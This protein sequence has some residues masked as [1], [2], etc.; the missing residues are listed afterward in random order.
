MQDLSGAHFYDTWVARD[1]DGSSFQP[2]F[3]FVTDAYSLERMALGLPFPVKCCWN[4]MVAMNA[5]PIV[6]HG[7][8]FRR[9]PG[10]AQPKSHS[11]QATTV[12]VHPHPDEC[13]APCTC[14]CL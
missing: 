12:H 7:M 4:G 2:D 10:G 8:R 1:I 5:A 6:R 11:L 14:I 9:A 13:G 3:P